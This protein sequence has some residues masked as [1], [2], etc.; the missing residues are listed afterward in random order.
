M[1]DPRLSD[2]Y[3]QRRHAIDEDASRVT[4][5]SADG[6]VALVSTLFS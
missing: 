5:S 3:V 1:P 2:I 6:R 4:Q